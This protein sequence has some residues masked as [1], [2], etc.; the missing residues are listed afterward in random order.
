MN[1]MDPVF[2]GMGR[3]ELY[4]AQVFPEL[5]PHE[6]PMMLNNWSKDDLEMYCGGEFA[7]GSVELEWVKHYLYVP[8]RHH[9]RSRVTDNDI[10]WGP[11]GELVYDR[12]YS[13]VKPDGTRETWP[14]TVGRVV[15]GNL[16]LWWTADITCRMNGKT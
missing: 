14:E 10:N 13:R 2:N 15:D 12:T 16:G 3:S 7:K 1:I 5:F 11:T 8:I 6:P 9:I 4:R